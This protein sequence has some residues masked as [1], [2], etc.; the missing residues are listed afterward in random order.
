VPGKKG[1]TPRL[2]KGKATDGKV[3]YLLSADRKLRRLSLRKMKE[4]A[5]AQARTRRG[6]KIAPNAESH[7]AAKAPMRP[8]A[9]VFMVCG[10]LVATTLIA[11][12][13]MSPRPEPDAVT[14]AALA[15]EPSEEVFPTPSEPKTHIAPTAPVAPVVPLL[16]APVPL[17]ARAA[18]PARAVVSAPATPRVSSPNPGPAAVPI[19]EPA[20]M[21]TDARPAADTTARRSAAA[22]ARLPDDG[23]STP[24][25]TI[26]GCLERTRDG[27]RLKD[28]EGADAPRSRN[29]KTG[30]L[31]KSAARTGLV[32][33]ANTLRPAD[34]VGQRVA[35]TGVLMD[36]TLRARALRRVAVSCE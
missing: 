18:E 28:T 32:P 34:Y 16:P 7:S 17:S 8:R 9:V 25:V 3:R 20:V 36:G 2:P 22:E 23:V 30:F 35:A 13:S 14:V 31:K 27:Y 12:S 1:K 6:P 5:A 19:A 26:T 21:A 15:P 29:W 33:A 11:A 10:L 24:D 4:R